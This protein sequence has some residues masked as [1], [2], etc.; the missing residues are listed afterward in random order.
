MR[1][2]ALAL[3]TALTVVIALILW[4]NSSRVEEQVILK[5]IHYATSRDRAFQYCN[6]AAHMKF[7]SPQFEEATEALC[8]AASAGGGGGG[9]GGAESQKASLRLST[10]LARNGIAQKSLIEDDLRALRAAANPQRA[11]RLRFDANRKRAAAPRRRA[12][13][14]GNEL[15]LTKFIPSLEAI[16]TTNV[17]FNWKTREIYRAQQPLPR[18]QNVIRPNSKETHGAFLVS[19]NA[20]TITINSSKFNGSFEKRKDDKPEYWNTT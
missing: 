7:P 11:Q 17:C 20:I 5:T 4:L 14:A 12:P 10:I 16:A 6:R 1:S 13:F 3:F 2:G 18:T 8:A 19:L 15:S 9:G